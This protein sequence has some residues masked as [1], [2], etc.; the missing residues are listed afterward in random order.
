MTPS[1]VGAWA[2]RPGAR[3]ISRSA[4]TGFGPRTMVRRRPS[5]A[6]TGASI[7]ARRATA[8]RRRSPSP[9][10]RTIRQPSRSCVIVILS[11]LGEQD[12]PAIGVNA[13][14]ASV[15]K[16]YV[17]VNFKDLT[18]NISNTI[19]AIL[20]PAAGR[21]DDVEPIIALRCPASRVEAPL[22]RRHA[23]ARRRQ[24]AGPRRAHRRSA[25]RADDAPRR[26]EPGG[27]A[28]PRRRGAG[29]AERPAML[30]LGRMTG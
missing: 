29:Q 6:M 3:P 15:K 21:D 1:V 22:C 8:R 9:V 19:I 27:A 30:P 7:A 16:R 26:G 23:L 24:G 11:R 5:A 10:S 17:S 28:I 2:M 18:I 12:A 14:A 25:G 13:I 20:T 4:R